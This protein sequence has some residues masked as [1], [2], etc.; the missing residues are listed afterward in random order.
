MWF[1]VHLKWTPF[2]L[3]ILS[4]LR[5][6]MISILHALFSCI[7]LSSNIYTTILLNAFMSL[8]GSFSPT[9]SS[10][11]SSSSIASSYSPSSSSLFFSLLSSTISLSSSLSSSSLSSFF[12]YCCCLYFYFFNNLFSFL[13]IPPGGAWIG[14]SVSPEARMAA[15][16]GCW[17]SDIAACTPAF[18]CV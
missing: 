10:S 2:S 8:T 11:S 13:L 4:K 17:S 18:N 9:F 5:K 6:S 14:P 15:K 3:N 12:Y 16:S 1:H 7:P